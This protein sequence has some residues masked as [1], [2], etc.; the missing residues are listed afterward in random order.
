MSQA[1]QDSQVTQLWQETA[2]IPLPGYTHQPFYSSRVS[3]Q[4]NK[5]PTHFS[6]DQLASHMDAF[7]PVKLFSIYI[8]LEQ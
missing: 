2:E 7:V 5:H 1:G 8:E 4:T 6:P 3:T